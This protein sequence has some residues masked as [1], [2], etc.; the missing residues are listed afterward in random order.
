M[1]VAIG[2][3]LPQNQL[4][5][6]SEPEAAALYTVR[7]IQPNTIKVCHVNIPFAEI[8]NNS[9]AQKGDTFI[10][11]DAGGGTVVWFLGD[12]SCL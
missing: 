1:K 10:V 6:L 2:A 9:L 7:V 4:S 5:L 8:N 11:C 12:S 3:G